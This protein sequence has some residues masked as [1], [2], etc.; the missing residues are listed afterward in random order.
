MSD[1]R[2]PLVS[3]CC[4]TYQHARF[5][6]EAIEGFLL[7]RT[8]FPIEIIIRDDASTDGTAAIVKEY[9]ERYPNLIR[10]ILNEENQFSKGVRP[11]PDA[12]SHAR[13]KYIAICEGDDYWTDPLKLQKQVDLMEANPDHTICFHR[14]HRL[15]D[16]ALE[17]FPIPDDIDPLNIRFDDLLRTYN[18]VITA[19]VLVRHTVLPLPKW[20]FRVPF[21]D[22][23][24]YA[25]A[26]SK[27]RMAM[28][29]DSMAVWRVTGSGAWTG[30][31]TAQ[32]DR[33][34]LRFFS[35]IRPQLTA[36]QQALVDRNRKVI[37]A[38]IATER[39][40]GNHRMKRLYLAGLHLRGSWMDSLEWLYAAW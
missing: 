13:G 29:P 18:F 14:A 3:V 34:F 15:M 36:A 6:R 21:G 2:T 10:A 19:S 30:L 12:M 38:R 9:A 37:L 20:F 4:T 25:L 32:Q 11:I 28:L 24:I 16:G 33:N 7:Q 23:A 35:G 26:G 1:S 27:G 31:S 8:S 39:F 40:P 22:L 17:P 5:I